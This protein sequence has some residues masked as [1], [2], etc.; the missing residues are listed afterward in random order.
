MS[1]KEKFMLKT[2]LGNTALTLEAKAGESILIKDIHIYSPSAAKY[3]TI[4]IDK[5]TVGYFRTGSVL[6]GHLTI[7]NLPNR[8]AHDFKISSAAITTPLNQELYDAN[9]Q[10]QLIA[11]IVTENIATDNKLLKR[12]TQFASIGSP[13]TSIL[14]Y[15]AKTEVFKGY[16]VGEGQV[17]TFAGVNEANAIQLVE[18]EVYDAGDILPTDENGSESAE[19]FFINYGRPGA[20]ITAG[21]STIYN[22][23]QS[24]PEFPDFPY[25][26]DVPANYEIDIVGVLASSIKD[27]DNVTDF[28]R[29]AYLKFI[30]DR[31][32]LFDDDKNGILHAGEGVAEVAQTIVA[33]GYSLIG[34]HSEVDHRPPLMFREPLIF[35][36]GEE[37]GVY[38]TTTESTSPGSIGVTYS[39][40]GLIEKVRKLG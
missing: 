10:A 22:T 27:Y 9:G 35:R 36:G 21:T 38:L 39:E 3:L 26:K 29:T 8:H 13:P 12:L 32:T 7:P 18:Y 11:A 34:N 17:V 4:S 14:A 30:K 31:I 2:V 19:Y 33:E 24:P 5:T 1:L 28:T 40:I 6:G 23:L 20:A 25:A 15:L 16:P 37:L